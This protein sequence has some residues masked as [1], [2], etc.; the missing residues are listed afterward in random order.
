MTKP[1]FIQGSDYA[2]D[3]TTEH[4]FEYSWDG[5]NVQSVGNIL[6]IKNNATIRKESCVV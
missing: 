3:A 6:T 4:V 5:S 2:F 1:K